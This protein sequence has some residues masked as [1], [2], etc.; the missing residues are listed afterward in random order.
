M[1]PRNALEVK[2]LL[3]ETSRKAVMLIKQY[4]DAKSLSFLQV[5]LFCERSLQAVEL[6]SS[7]QS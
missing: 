6:A 5:M 2:T 4:R 3:R 7:C 1:P